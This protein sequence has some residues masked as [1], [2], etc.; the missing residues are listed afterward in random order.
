MAHEP[1]HDIEEEEEEFPYYSYSEFAKKVREGFTRET[2]KG[3]FSPDHLNALY[4]MEDYDVVDQ[5]VKANPKSKEL[6][7]E[8]TASEVVPF[9]LGELAQGRSMLDSP[10]MREFYEGQMQSIPGFLVS[11]LDALTDENYDSIHNATLERLKRLDANPEIKAYREWANQGLSSEEWWSG[12]GIKR[13]VDTVNSG[14]HSVASTIGTGLIGAGT[15]FTVAGAPGAVAGFFTGGL[16]ST[17]GLEGG[18]GY[19]ESIRE[20]THDKPIIL[21]EY[22]KAKDEQ[23]ALIKSRTS[24]L[25]EIEQEMAA[26]EEANY[27]D[28]DGKKFK[29]GLSPAEAAQASL[30]S[31]MITGATNAAIEYITLGQGGKLLRV[32][33]FNSAFS[34]KALNGAIQGKTLKYID[35]QVRKLPVPKKG[36]PIDRFW[37]S[38][39]QNGKIISIGTTALTE[40][41]QEIAQEY[42]SAWQKTLGPAS[43]SEERF[44]EIFTHATMLKSFIAGFGTGTTVGGTGAIASTVID[45]VQN[46]RAPKQKSGVRYYYTKN[47][48]TG[49]YEVWV[50][51]EGVNR[52]VDDSEL[53][54]GNGKNKSNFQKRG[55][56]KRAV[57]DLQKKHREFED[58]SYVDAFG[59]FSENATVKIELDEASGL[60]V[61]NVYDGDKLLVNA[62]I[63]RTKNEAVGIKNN[64][65]SKLTW[66]E[67]IKKRLGVT[68]E[69]VDN[70]KEYQDATKN[71]EQRAGDTKRSQARA[72]LMSYL[73]MPIRDEDTQYLDQVK[74]QLKKNN[75]TLEDSPELIP[76]ILLNPDLG[77]GIL[78]EVGIPQ[79]DLVT[80]YEDMFGEKYPEAVNQLNEIL[81]P[82]LDDTITPPSDDTIIDTGEGITTP[83]SDIIGT[84]PESID[85]SGMPTGDTGGIIQGIAVNKLNTLSA[86]TLTEM[87]TI[88]QE[89]LSKDPK[90]LAARAN[91]MT[92]ERTLKEI[93]AP[94]EVDIP[95]EV[96][97]TPDDVGKKVNLFNTKGE[98][99]EVTIT[100]VSQDGSYKYK[101]NGKEFIGE[102]EELSRY[103]PKSPDFLI[104]AGRKNEPETKL[105]ELTDDEIISLLINKKKI[106]E[107]GINV[108][109]YTHMAG[110]RSNVKEWNALRV[111][112]ARRVKNGT[113]KSEEFTEE[114]IDF[115]TPKFGEAKQFLIDE[116]TL[117]YLPR[118]GEAAAKGGKAKYGVAKRGE[119]MGKEYSLD[120][121]PDSILEEHLK[122]YLKNEENI[123][124]GK[125]GK[126]AYEALNKVEAELARRKRLGL[127][128]IGE[129]GEAKPFKTKKEV[130]APKEA[131]KKISKAEEEAR[132]EIDRL[133]KIKGVSIKEDPPLSSG[134]PNPRIG[135]IILD[136]SIQKSGIGTQIV[137][138]FKVLK[139]EQGAPA[140][141][142]EA[143]PES[144]GFWEKQGFEVFTEMNE[145]YKYDDIVFMLFS[146]KKMDAFESE[147]VPKKEAAKE[148]TAQE[149]FDRKLAESM[150][151]PITQEQIYNYNKNKRKKLKKKM[152]DLDLEA[153]DIYF[154]LEEQGITGEGTQNPIRSHPKFQKKYKEYLD[155][156][157]EYEKQNLIHD[158]LIGGK[159]AESRKKSIPKLLA[160]PE[161]KLNQAIDNLNEHIKLLQQYKEGTMFQDTTEEKSQWQI[162]KAYLSDDAKKILNKEDYNDLKESI[163]YF[164]AVDEA[165]SELEF[166]PDTD[167]KIT[168][169]EYLNLS[170]AKRE[171]LINPYELTVE[172]AKEALSNLTSEGREDFIENIRTS[173]NN[174]ES[175]LKLKYNIDYDTGSDL[176]LYEDEIVEDEVSVAEGEQLP[177][178]FETKEKLNTKLDDAKK[179]L[180]PIVSK[181]RTKITNAIKETKSAVQG[182]TEE[183]KDIATKATKDLKKKFNEIQSGIRTKVDDITKTIESK[184]TKK[185]IEKKVDESIK[186]LN[187]YV[188]KSLSTVEAMHSVDFLQNRIMQAGF[189][190]FNIKYVD[191]PTV[192]Y[193]GKFNAKTN[194][195]IINL[196]KVTADT[197]FHE[198]SHPLFNSLLIHNPK[199]FNKLWADLEATEEG[200]A[201]IADKKKTYSGVQLQLEA[202]SEALGRESEGKFQAKSRISQVIQRFLDWVMEKLF[203]YKWF[204]VPEVA[205]LNR[206]NLTMGYLSDIL[207]GVSTKKLVLEPVTLEQL[208]EKIGAPI[209]EFMQ[210]DKLIKTA[211][212]KELDLDETSEAIE[213]IVQ[214]IEG[215]NRTIN[216]RNHKAVWFGPAQYDYTGAKD[217]HPARD[218][219]PIVEQLQSVVE[220]ELGLP[221]GYYDSVLIN[222]YEPG[223][224]LSAH[225]DNEALLRLDDGTIGSVGTLNLGG[226]SEIYIAKDRKNAN[227][228]NAE[229]VIE[230]KSG[231]VY[232]LPAGTFQDTYFHAVGPSKETRISLTFRRTK[233]AG[234]EKLQT[235]EGT[236]IDFKT[237]EIL[238][239][240][241]SVNVAKAF[242]MWDNVY[243]NLLAHLEEQGIKYLGLDEWN[244]VVRPKVPEELVN[245]YKDWLNEKF[246]L[247]DK[248]KRMQSNVQD[249]ESFEEYITSEVYQHNLNNQFDELED[250][251]DNIINTGGTTEKEAT[252][253]DF[254]VFGALGITVYEG[255]ISALAGLAKTMP[256]NEYKDY[257]FRATNAKGELLLKGIIE[258]FESLTKIQKKKLRRF[259]NIMNSS[260][261]VNQGNTNL[262]V[263]FRRNYKLILNFANEIGD[264][265]GAKEKV[266]QSISVVLKGPEE[267][268]TG[269][270]KKNP[271]RD[272]KNLYEHINAGASTIHWIGK[273]DTWEGSQIDIDFKGEAEYKY[274]NRYSWVVDS[275]QDGAYMEHATLL[276][277]IDEALRK[278]NL[279]LIMTKGATSQ[280]AV[281]DITESDK[282]DAEAW[283][284]YWNKE[285]KDFKDM[286]G[287]SWEKGTKDKILKIPNEQRAG[288]VA[289]HKAMSLIFPE[290]LQNKGQSK[291]DNIAK[292]LSIMFAPVTT[293]NTMPAIDV[294]KIPFESTYLSVGDEG[295]DKNK[296]LKVLGFKNM[297]DG[298]S[299]TSR[300]TFTL[301]G[302]HFGLRDNNKLAKTVIYAQVTDSKGRV[303][304]VAIKHEQYEYDPGI[305][306]HNE[307]GEIFARINDDG[308][309]VHVKDGVDGKIIHMMVTSD[310]VKIGTGEFAKA[311]FSVDGQ[312]I[313]FLKMEE[314]EKNFVKHGLQLYNHAVEDEIV[315]S[316]ADRFRGN[317]ARSIMSRLIEFLRK[318]MPTIKDGKITVPTSEKMKSL[319]SGMTKQGGTNY[320]AFAKE[321]MEN[322]AGMHYG[323]SHINDH[324]F[325]TG[326]VSNILQMSGQ[327]GTYATLVPNLKM[328]LKVG[329]SAISVKA[330][331]EIIK[332]Y[333]DDNNIPIKRHTENRT[334]D[335]IEEYSKGEGLDAVNEWLQATVEEDGFYVDQRVFLTRHP[336]PHRGGALMSRVARLH[337]RRGQIELHPED[338]YNKIEAD[339]DGDS[340]AIEYLPESQYD[341]FKEYFDNLEV[342]GIPLDVFK[343]SQKFSFAT[344][345]D[346]NALALALQRGANGIKEIAN[347]QGLYG[348]LRRGFESMNITIQVPTEVLEGETLKTKWM[349]VDVGVR[350]KNPNELF[351]WDEMI[352][353][354]GPLETTVPEMLRYYLQAAVDNAKYML[355][356]EWGYDRQKLI[357]RL[358]HFTGTMPEGV[359]V[360]AVKRRISQFIIN[361]VVFERQKTDVDGNLIFKDKTKKIPVMETLKVGHSTAMHIRNGFTFE[362]PQLTFSDIA[363]LSSLY[364]RFFNDKEGVYYRESV[365]RANKLLLT[366]ND[367]KMTGK[368]SPVEYIAVSVYEAIQSHIKANK[369]HGR[370]NRSPMRI[371]RDKHRA[372]HIYAIN[373]IQEEKSVLYPEK[374]LMLTDR[375]KAVVD[376]L[377]LEAVEYYMDL[378]EKWGELLREHVLEGFAMDNNP[379]LIKLAEEFDT[380]FRKFTPFQK[381]HATY[382]FLQGPEVTYI[383]P[384]SRKQL[385]LSTLDSEL[386]NLYYKKYNEAVDIGNFSTSDLLVRE[387]ANILA[388]LCK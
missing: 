301:Y 146:K 343:R 181:V 245:T 149:W 271:E 386:L 180:I 42:N 185:N 265:P 7:Y 195:I 370:S 323:T 61:V 234:K 346:R 372:A 63:G 90:N 303:S 230:A 163:D 276:D 329:E 28:K 178:D 266:L 69:D 305:N 227:K 317:G 44:G 47:N 246:A 137:N 68:K 347:I 199:L 18:A 41:L 31:N 67:K 46:L 174:L 361:P 344:P 37:D 36:G 148:E 335:M 3:N 97:L 280:F 127:T 338:V 296:S 219:P 136:K 260:I 16:L 256:W 262:G 383:P 93:G 221:R 191:Y 294:L 91:I 177:I 4:E 170:E 13:L 66:T 378:K 190:P 275:P 377:E 292:R 129:V 141:V 1:F 381:L 26:W 239:D 152:L 314:Y 48:N 157:I 351:T 179:K 360:D 52:K 155:A 387:P 244:K 331:R 300:E 49:M 310:E 365:K 228:E 220:K 83:P 315:D 236:I 78:L 57:I 325:Q 105:S 313:G 382:L 20:L 188:A 183:A 21:E 79:E 74:N 357:S 232:E 135:K 88:E 363:D 223:T 225:Q 247:D 131:P 373:H 118:G 354:K 348:M 158:F 54:D 8:P 116:K 213:E 355:L 321:H 205:S 268:I 353:D 254:E 189:T 82:P 12:S 311:E 371:T 109:N 368:A 270:R 308:N 388:A 50:N 17:Y 207:A 65:T 233:F 72:I 359:D 10:G 193:R 312:S 200:Q 320:S 339:Q 272:K 206:K 198:F 375:S 253:K 172:E 71:K 173:L 145:N 86:D 226:T 278:V 166:L 252:Q 34:K 58:L 73:G 367:V 15:G 130:G 187:N 119:K 218:M 55:Q 144:V 279:A 324:I 142:I 291:A 376:Q 24:N 70:N 250:S 77:P 76:E 75:K 281:V 222:I 293:S 53:I 140:I 147:G 25:G 121:I 143:F 45:N 304:T 192:D 211:T 214:D 85:T 59:S 210:Q 114:L 194:T 165:G 286:Y 267:R 62:G 251:I 101:L 306:F 342:S 384:S 216:T 169:E 290:Y 229:E 328:D 95:S 202:L 156:A 196:A 298:G 284:E 176:F 322:G 154:E 99:V 299:L 11:H 201:I 302:E 345:K 5:Y 14:L 380:R 369:L 184:D 237:G 358:F 167:D 215:H 96:I 111:E 117:Y 235:T 203:G 316:W 309:I 240:P 212:L 289:V 283:R 379:K 160:A 6:L 33:G 151:T 56:A 186:D 274:T 38:V 242:A 366:V 64:V 263:S 264:R 106:I 273:N 23:K 295:F 150:E 110:W 204:N 287:V 9:G 258:N 108:K 364:H 333:L 132:K 231:D 356:D 113:W 248:Y 337:T 94:K 243:N 126:G 261:K 29:K 197:P 336:V 350:L 282:K 297:G 100:G 209:T 128:Y 139:K 362:N 385:E 334:I 2:E 162:E 307:N 104:R 35:K 330:G 171:K 122:L 349:P 164:N 208:Q 332:A 43:W 285:E 249:Q 153:N 124:A 255:E 175:D 102:V 98:Q 241:D 19:S 84:P 161:S 238:W 318:G 134:K 319:L 103:N 120:T 341:I 27:I 327:N 89:N 39:N 133:S 217:K 80:A 224:T 269:K 168:Y 87:L 125:E 352:T 115:Y 288:Q 182:K 32:A 30:L 107:K 340:V 277:A 138:A 159:H 257:V 81:T 374:L 60:Y 326:T 22:L 40:G 112:Q 123:R 259:Y 51:E 92:L